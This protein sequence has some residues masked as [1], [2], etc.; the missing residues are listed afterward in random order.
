MKVPIFHLKGWAS[1]PGG[2]VELTPALE[3]LFLDHFDSGVS[4]TPVYRQ[5]GDS[6]IELVG[7]NL[8]ATPARSAS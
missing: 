1:L 7:F 8:T 6:P 4:L 5:S 3:E 2:E